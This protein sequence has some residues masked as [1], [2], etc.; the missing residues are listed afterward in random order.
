MREDTN[1]HGLRQWFYFQMRSKKTLR[2]KLRIYRFSKQHSLYR[3]GMKPF[4]KTPESPWKQMGERVRYEYD[5]DQKCYFLEWEHEFEE[6][7][8]TLFATLPPY[9][10][11]RLGEFI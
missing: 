7:K 6:G 1:T 4:V 10:Y 2:L 5:P 8:E 3:H 9:T 11:T